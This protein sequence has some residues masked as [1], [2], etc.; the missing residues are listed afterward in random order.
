V[1][2]SWESEDDVNAPK[3]I[4]KYL[5]R[6]AASIRSTQTID[7]QD[8]YPALQFP[9][10]KH[11]EGTLYLHPFQNKSSDKLLMGGQEFTRNNTWRLLLILPLPA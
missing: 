8:M 5:Q 1:H 9:E 7:H 3:V 10:M 4:A 6:Q 2:D 11:Q